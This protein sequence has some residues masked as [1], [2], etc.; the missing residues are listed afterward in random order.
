MMAK[1]FLKKHPHWGVDLFNE[2][3]RSN[4]RI[5]RY[6]NTEYI[7]NVADDIVKNHPH[8]TWKIVSEL[9]VSESGYHYE[10]KDWL[11]NYGLV[12][13]TKRGAI[14]YMPAG[15]IIHW[16]KEDIKSR[17]GLI[18]DVLP[19]TLDMDAGGRLTRLFIEEFCDDDSVGNS[20]YWRFCTGGWSGP[21]SDYLSRKR[22][23]ARQW[24]SEISSTKI[25]I[26]LG[27]YLEYLDNRIE[28]AKIREEREF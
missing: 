18:Q 4:R 8:E 15:D 19:K 3:M 13:A 9:L 27:K 2:I 24:M 11:G 5:S 17:Q 26:W 10:L 16:I 28:T 6:G 23:A 22:D 12:D 14:S 7:A 21:E 20:L 1:G 25:Q